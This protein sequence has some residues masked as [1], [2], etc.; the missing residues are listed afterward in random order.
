M[1]RANKIDCLFFLGLIGITAVDIL[2]TIYVWNNSVYLSLPI[3]I[4][5][6]EYCSDIRGD[7]F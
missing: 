5:W 6:Q 7:Q 2:M 1:S 4:L 3:L